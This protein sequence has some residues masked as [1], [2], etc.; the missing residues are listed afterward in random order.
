[1]TPDSP[2][3]KGNKRVKNILTSS[4]PTASIKLR[5]VWCVQYFYKCVLTVLLLAVTQGE[6]LYVLICGSELLRTDV[7]PNKKKSE[8]ASLS[9]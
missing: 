4:L 9:V 3:M 7:E 2:S 8:K 6:Y 5:W 1:M